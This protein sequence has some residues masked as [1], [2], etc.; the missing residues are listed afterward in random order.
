MTDRKRRKKNKLRGQRTM[1]AGNTKNRRGAGCRGGRGKAG[2]NK[3]RFHSMRRLRLRR[4]KLKIDMKVNAITLK[5]LDLII[6]Q[7]AIQGKVK[8]EGDSYIVD[9]KS[10]YTKVLS[11]GEA[12][13]KIILK[14]NASTK[15]IAKIIKAGGKFEFAKEGYVADEANAEDEDL[16]FEEAE[17]GDSA[18]EK[19]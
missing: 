14:I 9:S 13:H 6:E 11:Q 3:H 15:A 5:Q 8:K 19:E 7:L 10:G 4:Y 18:K 16:E 2:S 12:T 17:E 1:G